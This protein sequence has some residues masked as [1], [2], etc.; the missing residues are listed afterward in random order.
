MIRL[1]RY[2]AAV[3]GHVDVLHTLVE[4]GADV[5][6]ARDTGA[7]PVYISSERGHLDAL[8]IIISANADVR[9]FCNSDIRILSQ[10]FRP[11]VRLPMHAH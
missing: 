1:H 10:P 7:T 5:N 6:I 4:Y 3:N 2:M 11:P 8:R 9:V